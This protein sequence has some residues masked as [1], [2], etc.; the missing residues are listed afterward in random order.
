MQKNTTRSPPGPHGHH[1]VTTFTRHSLLQRYL[2]GQFQN[3]LTRIWCPPGKTYVVYALGLNDDFI[4]TN[5]L[6][7]TKQEV[8]DKL[9]VCLLNL[10]PKDHTLPSLLAI[11]LLNVEV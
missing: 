5:V 6:D 10:L 2:L 7:K 4:Q 3:N 11:S 8:G 9:N 1:T